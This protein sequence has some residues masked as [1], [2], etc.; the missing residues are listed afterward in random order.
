MCTTP[1]GFRN[2]IVVPIG[3]PVAS[4]D[5]GYTKRPPRGSYIQSLF[6]S[7]DGE[8]IEQLGGGDR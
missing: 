8:H 7:L 6:I 3:S 4:F 2:G 5:V 1:F